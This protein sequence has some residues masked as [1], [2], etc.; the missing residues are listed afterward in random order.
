MEAIEHPPGPPRVRTPYERS[1]VIMAYTTNETAPMNVAAHAPRYRSNNPSPPLGR[2]TRSSRRRLDLPI[3]TPTPFGG[4][5]Q[6][7]D[8][9]HCNRLTEHDP[10]MMSRSSPHL[11]D[12]PDNRGA[13]RAGDPH[14]VTCPQSSSHRNEPTKTRFRLARSPAHSLCRSVTDDSG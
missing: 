6:C 2:P 3:A 14:R 5:Y 13:A 12:C 11:D 9:D 8:S 10:D 1:T 7:I 4:V